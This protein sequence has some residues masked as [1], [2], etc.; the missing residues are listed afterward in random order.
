ME[1]LIRRPPE[2]DSWYRHTGD[3]G[4]HPIRR[5]PCTACSP[6][7]WELRCQ[8]SGVNG[9]AHDDRCYHRI[10]CWQDIDV[11]RRRDRELYGGIVIE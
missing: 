1:S 6:G 8:E 2:F 10:N 7:E 3:I 4:K 9:H 5:D 11:L